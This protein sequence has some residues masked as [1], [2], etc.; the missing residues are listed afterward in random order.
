MAAGPKPPELLRRVRLEAEYADGTGPGLEFWSDT[1][2]AAEHDGRPAN[3][4]LVV[5]PAQ[6]SAEPILQPPVTELVLLAAF[7]QH[8]ANQRLWRGPQR[9][10]RAPIQQ[11]RLHQPRRRRRRPF[12]RRTPAITFNH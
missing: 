1:R 8:V 10:Q 9:R 7:G 12:L 6:F 4:D 3:D 5:Q 11:P 2:G